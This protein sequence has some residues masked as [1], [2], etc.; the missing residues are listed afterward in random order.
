MK[1]DCTKNRIEYGDFI[2]AIGI[3]LVVIGHINSYN[4]L[5]KEWIYSF[6]MPLFFFAAGVVSV[7]GSQRTTNW[8][9]FV[10]GK[11][12]A[13][14]IPYALWGVAYS[15]V[16]FYKLKMLA[17]GSYYS[18]IRS[19]SLSS[20][21]FLPVM[22]VAVSVFEVAKNIDK[23]SDKKLYRVFGLLLFA[24]AFVLPSVKVGY[25]FGVDAALVAAAFMLWGYSFEK[26]ASGCCGYKSSKVLW[27]MFA[28]GFGATLT[29]LLNKVGGTGYVLMAD[30]HTGN[31]VL[32]VTAAAGGCVMIYAVARLVEKINITAVKTTLE[33]IGRNTLVIFVIHKP[34]I[35]MFTKYVDVINAPDLIK[36][37]LVTVLVML[38]CVP[39]IVIINRFAPWLAGKKYKNKRL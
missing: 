18:I 23:S 38:T 13:L 24:V 39:A 34:L 6:H 33:F 10:T 22:F 27:I 21:W 8:K 31:A 1:T 32:F 12:K 26:A 9:K 35:N 15:G 20:L 16:S 3:I 14:L 28:V 29:E 2:K 17:Y 37:V 25:P 11:V 30:M 19:E 36:L 7:Y 5:V 4:G